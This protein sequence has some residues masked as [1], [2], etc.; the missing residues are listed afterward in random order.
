MLTKLV[1]AGSVALLLAYQSLWQPATWVYNDR[2]LTNPIIVSPS[3]VLEKA[4]MAVTGTPRSARLLN[5]LLHACN[6]VLVGL[7][8][9]R[10]VGGYI[11]PIV[12]LAWML[13]PL[14]VESVAYGAGRGELL[15][16]TGVLIAV[17]AAVAGGRGW[18][19]WALIGGVLGMAAKESA[20]VVL[21]LVPL[22]RFSA[23]YRWKLAAGVCAGTA[24]IAIALFGGPVAIINQELYSAHVTT[25]EWVLVQLTAVAR[26][27]WLA[28]LPFNQT[29][30]YD[31]DIIPNAVRLLC[32]IALFTWVWLAL[33]MRHTLV[34]LG[35]L[36]T[37]IAV[38]PRLFVQT[39]RSYLNEHQFYTP[40][41]G[42]AIML[43]GLIQARRSHGVI[44]EEEGTAGRREADRVYAPA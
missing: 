44:R 5:L 22:V 15:A 14:Q 4:T 28:V 32:A 24:I 26:L 30:D 33:R 25:S 9:N 27:T 8:L 35:I 40:L 16:A 38:A 17:L 6:A 23:G 41:I 11:A 21:A 36:W 7:L 13:H 19:W 2:M 1:I 10:L 39:P 20:I 34:T 18:G 3:R 42:F 43:C 29:I 37:L 31:Y 12:T